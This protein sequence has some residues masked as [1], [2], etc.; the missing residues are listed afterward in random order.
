M[1]KQTMLLIGAFL[2][3]AIFYVANFTDFLKHKV[4]QIRWGN[5]RVSADSVVFYLDKKYSLKSV[6]VVSTD[7]ARTNRTPHALWHLVADSA[8]VPLKNFAYGAAIPGMKPKIST[9]IPEP[10]MPGTDYSLLVEDA[11]GLKGEKS[12]S[13]H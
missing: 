7:D 9:A 12:F 10:L 6:E 1:N 8:P 5:S 3:L 13:I 2:V 11:S 4:I